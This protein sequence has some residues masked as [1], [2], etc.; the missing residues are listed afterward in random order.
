MSTIDLTT[1]NK[2][3]SSPNNQ[4]LS[5][6]PLAM[7]TN[8]TDQTNTITS[9]TLIINEIKNSS[10]VKVSDNTKNN[11]NSVLTINQINNSSMPAPQSMLNASILAISNLSASTIGNTKITKIN[12]PS[13]PSLS[14]NQPIASS[15]TLAEALTP[16]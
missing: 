12:S 14:A 3:S 10:R 15:V 8:Q 13:I 7:N 11:I 9:T 6:L 16:E 5:I 4:N 1:S 2:N